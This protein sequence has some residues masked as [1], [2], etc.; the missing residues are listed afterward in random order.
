MSTPSVS[1][2]PKAEEDPALGDVQR[3]AGYEA[4]TRLRV[5]HG[6][7]FRRVFDPGGSVKCN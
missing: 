5:A 1:V 4:A 7:R 6:V 3:N 2:E